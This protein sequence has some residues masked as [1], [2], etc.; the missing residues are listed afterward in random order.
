MGFRS[1]AIRS[2]GAQ[3]VVVTG[4]GIITPMGLGWENNAAGFRAGNSVIKPVSLFD[5]STQKAKVAGEIRLPENLPAP[6]LNP[7]QKH[8]IDRASAMLIHA[9]AEALEASGWQLNKIEEPL[10]VCLGTSAGAMQIG[11][12]YYRAAVEGKSR[13]RQA[14]RVTAYQTQRQALNLCDGFGIRGPVTIISNACSSGANAIGHAFKLVATGCARRALAGGYDALCKMV[15]AGFD[16]LQAL[17]TTL[18]RPFAVDRD[19]LALGEGASLFCIERFDDAIRRGGNIYAEIAGYGAATD[20]HHLTQPHPDG[21]AALLSMNRACAEAGL[22]SDQV[23]YINSHGTGT[24][25]NDSAEACAISRW[26]GKSVENLAVSSTKGGIGHLLGGAGAVESA[27]CLMA[28]EGSWIPPNAAVDRLDPICKFNLV[29]EPRDLPG[30]AT[31][32]TN[33]FG[34]GG[35]NATLIFNRRAS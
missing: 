12:E 13:R 22:N 19:G 35:A 11:E 7:R 32:L 9:A 17:S 21:D 28:M 10:P 14:E 24:P 15:F 27:I 6:R 5:V 3:R 20:Q 4:V 33:S 8:R 30:I 18:P 25:L 23:G 16:S 34:F 31:S 26:A 1:K 29:Q 2:N